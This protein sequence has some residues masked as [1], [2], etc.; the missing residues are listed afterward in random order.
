MSLSPEAKRLKLFRKAFGITQQEIAD[1][2]GKSKQLVGQYEN[3]IVPMPL[4]FVKAMHK[5]FEMNY[6]W[7]L[8]GVGRLKQ[9]APE[10]KTTLY[11]LKEVLLENAILKEKVAKLE[12]DFKELHAAFY[13]FKYG[14]K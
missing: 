14:S 12:A 4:D 7:F 13:A 9:E 6:T 2:I 5:H 8:S 3:G 11:D 1:K 10:K